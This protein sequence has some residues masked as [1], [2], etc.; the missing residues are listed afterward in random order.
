MEQE[1]LK[2]IEE[3]REAERLTRQGLTFELDV[4]VARP[5]GGLFGRWRAPI[6]TKERRTYHVPEPTLATL[7][8]LSALWVEIAIDEAALKGEDPVKAARALT[9]AQCRR[10]ALIVAV[11]VMGEDYY[12]TDTKGRRRED[13]RGLED[14]TDTFMHTMT[15]TDLL[16]LT[17]LITS[18][19]NLG[20][21]TASMRLMSASRTTAPMTTDIEG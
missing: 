12:I 11:A 17:L 4:P 5:R 16:T 8:R 3:R 6:R 13:R 1:Q 21:F 9:A 15:P 18:A 7:D 14:M 10:A 19:C 2:L 20:D